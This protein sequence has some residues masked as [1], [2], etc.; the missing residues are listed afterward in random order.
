MGLFI[1]DLKFVR[2]NEISFFFKHTHTLLHNRGVSRVVE[3]CYNRLTG[4][5]IVE[6]VSYED[7]SLS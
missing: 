2:Y 1:S 7:R 6:P 4:L 5:S 3:A